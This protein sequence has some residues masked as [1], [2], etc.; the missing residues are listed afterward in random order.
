MAIV[1]V[2]GG[3]GGGGLSMD[4][5]NMI[6]FSDSN[7]VSSVGVATETLCLLAYLLCCVILYVMLYS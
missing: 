4:E 2:D 7:G 1:V 5:C 3:S 6:V